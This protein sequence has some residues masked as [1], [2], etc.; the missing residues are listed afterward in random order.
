MEEVRLGVGHPLHRVLQHACEL[1]EAGL[2]EPCV[3]GALEERE[4]GEVVVLEADREEAD[5]LA[6]ALD[7]GHVEPEP[8]RG[9]GQVAR[10]LRPLRRQD[11]E[12]PVHLARACPRGDRVEADAVVDAE[13]HEPGAQ[14][15]VRWTAA[16]GVR[17]AE[18][19][20]RRPLLETRPR[21]AGGDRQLVE[22]GTAAH[23][24][25]AAPAA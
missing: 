2:R 25:A 4:P 11:R 10:R 23:D 17:G 8:L 14:R 12:V 9:R 7:R 16:V 21:L 18:H 5:R 3:P 15:G 6:E 20:E 13:P 19:A 22:R 1:E 24:G